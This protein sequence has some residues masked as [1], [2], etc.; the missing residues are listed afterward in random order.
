[1]KIRKIE[2]KNFRNYQDFSFENFAIPNGESGSGLT[3]FAG[4]NGCGKTNL[5]DALALALLEYKSETFDIDDLNDIEKDCEISVF[6]NEDFTVK[7]TIS[8]DFQSKGFL[9]KGYKRKKD[10]QSYLSSLTTTGRKY[11]TDNHNL[12]DYE[13][14]IDNN[15]AFGFARYDELDV[16]Y[17]DKNRFYQIKS[18]TFNKSRFDRLMDDF[19][20]QLLNSKNKEEDANDVMDK[21]ITEIEA[22]RKNK[23][24]IENEF[25]SKAVKKF[26]EI[27]NH[28]IKLNFLNNLKPFSSAFFA[29]KTE[30]NIQLDPSKIGSGYKSVFSL[31]Y[32]FYLAKQSK[33]NLI[34]LID[35]PELHL[36]PKLQDKFIKILFEFSKE[37]QIILTTHSPLFVKQALYNKNVKI[38]VVK[39]GKKPDEIHKEEF[40]LNEDGY[41][42]ANEVNFVAFDLATE[43]YHNEL[44]EHLQCKSDNKD[45]A[46]QSFDTNFFQ[47]KKQ[48]AIY[49]TEK[50]GNDKKHSI[51][52]NIRHQIHHRVTGKFY[53]NKQEFLYDYQDLE[54]SIN[55]MRQSLRDL[56][57]QDNILDTN[58]LDDITF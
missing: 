57:K 43:E 42:S 22:S 51:H 20:L 54:S 5:L 55:F 19:N 36:H 26:K 32:S 41:A 48:E 50:E 49:Y 35:E 18:G 47:N 56:L 58:H 40:L 33:K 52:T 17:L 25:L 30:N 15:T 34:I 21:A 45:K 10:S 6:S 4:E 24:K 23:K 28:E 13:L 31:L 12:K 16:V 27:S 39:E 46:I 44:Y 38:N 3:I 11:L 2:V 29:L 8:G 37:C 9:F 53:K 7:K 1:M 14:K